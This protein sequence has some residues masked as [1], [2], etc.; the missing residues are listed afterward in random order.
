MQEPDGTDIPGFGIDDCD[1][2]FGDT[3][4]RV[5]MWQGKADLSRLAGKPLRIRFVL[6]DADLYSFRFVS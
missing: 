6:Q 1:E 4:D 3:V 5:V 2:I